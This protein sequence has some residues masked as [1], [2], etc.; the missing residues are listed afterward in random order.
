[1]NNKGQHASIDALIASLDVTLSALFVPQSMS[2]N[3][4]AER[5]TLNWLLSI[6]RK[7]CPTIIN[8][9]YHQGIGHVPGY[10]KATRKGN[11]YKFEQAAETGVYP[12]RTDYYSPDLNL[13]KPDIRDVLHCVL[14]DAEAADY[15]FDEW[16]DDYGYEKDSR[17]AES[18]YQ[19]CQKTGYA[20]LRM[21]SAAELESLREAFQDY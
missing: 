7:G 3:A 8:T 18:I 2:R 20:L 5:P 19:E 15:S 11:L 13:P 16:A 9:D 6:T 1:M 12:K 10:Q 17:K 4:A 14:L 21:F